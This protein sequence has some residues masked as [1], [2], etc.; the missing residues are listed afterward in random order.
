[1][2]REAYLKREI[3]REKE[4]CIFDKKQRAKDLKIKRDI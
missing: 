1:M 2:K 3:D 4:R